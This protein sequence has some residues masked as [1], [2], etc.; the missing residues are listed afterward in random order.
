MELFGNLRLKTGRF[1]LHKRHTPVKRIKQDFDLDSVKKVGILWDASYESDF[2][3]LAA[4]NRQLVQSG[5]TVEVIAWIPGKSVPDKLTGLTYMKFLRKNDLNWVYLPVSEDARSF[6]ATKFD[7]VID[8]NPSS[9]FPLTS[10]CWL[11]SSP[12]KVG[13]DL[14]DEPE[15]APYD[16]MIRTSKPF[17]IALFLEQV[18]LYLSMISNPDTRA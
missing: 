9:L 7:L 8:I 12:M 18:M 5:K 2:Q 17:S 16:L 1:L 13:P 14:T 4:L 3:H 15:K 10:L 6:I 11:S